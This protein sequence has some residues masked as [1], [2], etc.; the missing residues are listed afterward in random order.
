MPT[1]AQQLSML[2]LTYKNSASVLLQRFKV[3]H[4]HEV[5]LQN[6]HAP[7]YIRDDIQKTSQQTAER[8]QF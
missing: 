4:L 1:K 6:N 7:R 8:K 2:G 3:A 5:G